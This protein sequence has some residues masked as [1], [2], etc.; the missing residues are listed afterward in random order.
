MI[1]ADDLWRARDLRVSR[2]TQI[3]YEWQGQKLHGIQR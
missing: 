2:I 3:D 1:D